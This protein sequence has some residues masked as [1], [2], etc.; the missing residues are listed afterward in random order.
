ML[1]AVPLG[2]GDSQV[3]FAC[4]GMNMRVI[5]VGFKSHFGIQIIIVVFGVDFE[6]KLEYAVGKGSPSNEDDSVKET[7]RIMGGEK[8]DATGAVLF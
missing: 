5:D 2:I 8:V 1:T 3:Y 7:N 4:F 6:L